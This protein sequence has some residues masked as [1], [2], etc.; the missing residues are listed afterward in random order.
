MYILQS[1]EQLTSEN[2]LQALK[3]T[4]KS[5]RLK[6]YIHINRCI[7]LKELKKKKQA[8]P[9]E[10]KP[11]VERPEVYEHGRIFMRIYESTMKRLEYYH[12]S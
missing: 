12:C 6:Y 4:S 9:K 2:W 7:S 5:Q 3:L 8:A 1:A 10:E 11:Q